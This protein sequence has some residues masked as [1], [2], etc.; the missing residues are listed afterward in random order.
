MG[1]FSFLEQMWIT[2]KA[3]F[4]VI[5]DLDGANALVASYT[6]TLS[7]Q[8]LSMYDLYITT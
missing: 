7:G 1:F 3:S 8:M 6:R 5:A 2:S 4:Q